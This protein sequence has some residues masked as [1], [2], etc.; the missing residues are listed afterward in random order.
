MY[1]WLRGEVLLAL[2]GVSEIIKRAA[3]QGIAP[4]ELTKKF[5]AEFEKDFN[6]LGLKPHTKNPRAT[7]YVPK[8]V[9]AIQ[10]LIEN[11]RSRWVLDSFF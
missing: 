2:Q 10:K 7:A 11:R 3:E 1:L 5:I 9:A 6:A 4:A 8:M